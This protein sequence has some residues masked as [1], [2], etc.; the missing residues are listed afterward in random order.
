METVLERSSS[1]GTFKNNRSGRDPVLGAADGRLED[2]LIGIL[3]GAPPT[4]P[5]TS[6]K[7]AID[8]GSP[9]STHTAWK[10]KS[11]PCVYPPSIPDLGA[12][13]GPGGPAGSGGRRAAQAGPTLAQAPVAHV[14]D[15]PR[16]ESFLRDERA[17][18]DPRDRL[19]D[20]LV[21]VAEGL[22]GPV[23]LDA[24]LVLDLA[25]KWSSV[26]V[27][28]PQSVWWMRMI[29][30]VP[31]SR[32]EIVSERISSSVTTPPAFRIT[33]ASPSLRPRTPYGFSLASMQA[34]T[35]TFFAGGRAGRLCRTRLRKPRCCEQVVGSAHRR[36]PLVRE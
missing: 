2:D 11:L 25:L 5:R 6:Q 28:I 34:T 9:A 35:A 26:K 20:I 16:T 31:N 22:G 4:E 13:Y 36:S 15:E 8:A 12:E 14:V 30:S 3:I 33:C 1:S 21:E 18:L 27:S 10:R 32:W 19:A 17:G 7:P 29:S 23:G 24:G